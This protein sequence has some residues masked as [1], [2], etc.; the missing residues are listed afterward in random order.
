MLTLFLSTVNIVWK[1]NWSFLYNVVDVYK[2]LISTLTRGFLRLWMYLI[3]FQVFVMH[4]LNFQI[5]I[6]KENSRINFDIMSGRF[7]PI[8][9]VNIT[10]SDGT[11]VSVSHI[12]NTK[13]DDTVKTDPMCVSRPA[14][15]A[16]LDISS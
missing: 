16:S 8:E 15:C 9:S 10:E 11:A 6:S 4:I 14:T 3:N 12:H 1:P 5:K 2:Y 7:S 13:W